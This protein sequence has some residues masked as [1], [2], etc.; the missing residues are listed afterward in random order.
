MAEVVV[1]A[2]PEAEPT[3][4]VAPEQVEPSTAAKVGE[5]EPLLNQGKAN[6]R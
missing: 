6:P 2:K 3:P 4:V 5:A 1:E